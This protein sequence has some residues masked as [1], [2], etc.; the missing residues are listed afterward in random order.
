MKF[1]YN[2]TASVTKK[3]LHYNDICTNLKNRGFPYNAISAREM[4]ANITISVTD[5]TGKSV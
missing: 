4:E 1:H 5:N 3:Q 2:D